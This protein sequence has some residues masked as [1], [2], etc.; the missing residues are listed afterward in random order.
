[1]RYIEKLEPPED[2]INWVTSYTKDN[3]KSPEYSNVPGNYK[4]M[5]KNQ[6]II[7]QK[8]L[9]CYC[10][11]RITNE[12]SHIEHFF[13]RHLC[14]IENRKKQTD[15]YNMF[16]SC[17]G[18]IENLSE[19]EGEFCGHRKNNWYDKQKVISPLE[20]DC[21]TCFTYSS[22]GEIK[23][24]DDN[25]KAIVM[26]KHLGLDEYAL[27]EAR[28]KALEAI[29]YFDENFD[30]DSAKQ[31]VGQVDENGYLPSFC[32]IIEYFAYK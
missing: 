19:V 16:A 20:K 21:D 2:Y 15:Y 12:T 25:E 23:A 14:R 1:M 26:I 8:G 27:N 3:R 32:N 18:Y 11:G 6:F 4:Q 30:K 9:C 22:Q 10:C 28:K 29:G 17:Y 5:L 7:E 13:P 24:R 31:I